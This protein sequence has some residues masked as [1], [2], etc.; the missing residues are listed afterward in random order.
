M[1]VCIPSK[2][3]PK[4]TTHKLFEEIGLDVFHFVEPQEVAAYGHLKN[5]VDIGASSQ[6][7]GFVRNFMLAWAQA[8]GDEWV[9]F[10]D[11]DVSAFSKYENNKS[12]RTN[13][14]IW[15]KILAK[16]KKTPFEMFGINYRQ[17]M[18][19]GHLSNF[20][21]NSKF[22]EVCVLVNV[23][24]IKWQYRPWFNLKEDRDFCLQT[25]KN[26]NGIVR[27]NR[28][29]V[30]CPDVG[31]NAGGLNEEY[32]AKKDATAAKRV[33]QEYGDYVEIVER[34]GRVEAKF[35]VPGF[36]KKHGKKVVI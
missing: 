20:S 36:A 29:G 32:K 26:G 28:L 12:L 11:D 22:V 19:Y 18:W 14:E 8:R 6:G 1:I 7:I 9:I 2:G 21:I 16:A 30:S 3:R 5:V 4:T 13:A 27:F 23:K 25:I 24:K 33:K 31:T 10:C 17:Y 34:L 35:D 15:I